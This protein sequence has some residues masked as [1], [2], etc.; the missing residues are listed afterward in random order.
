L[1]DKRI[2]KQQEGRK[3]RDPERRQISRQRKIS[4]KE[5]EKKKIRAVNTKIFLRTFMRKDYRRVR[6]ASSTSSLLVEIERKSPLEKDLLRHNRV[7]GRNNN[8]EEEEKE[9]ER[10]H[11]ERGRLQ[12]GPPRRKWAKTAAF[13]EKEGDYGEKSISFS[14]NPRRRVAP[15]FQHCSFEGESQID[16]TTWT[17][18]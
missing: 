3:R 13:R 7:V 9:S 18:L 6:R 8:W 15:S 10:G 1:D 5:P 11:R 17:N 14:R 2:K 16:R 4:S 12:K